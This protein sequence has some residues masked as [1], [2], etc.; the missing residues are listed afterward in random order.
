M[1][2]ICHSRKRN[3]PGILLGRMIPDEPE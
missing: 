2:F 3:A 1:T